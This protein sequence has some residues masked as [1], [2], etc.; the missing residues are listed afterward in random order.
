ML[1]ATV[2]IIY[3]A[4]KFISNILT[5]DLKLVIVVSRIYQSIEKSLLAQ[6]EYREQNN[7]VYLILRNRV[8]AHEKT[9]SK[10]LMN[11]IEE[12]WNEYNETQKAILLYLFRKGSA[13]L[14]DL[15]Q[16][17]GINQNSVRSYQSIE[18]SEKIA[19]ALKPEGALNVQLRLVNGKAIPFELNTRFSSTECV[20]AYYGYN[21][22]E[23][24]LDNYLF[25]KEIDL[26]NWK[27]GMFM[28][29]WHECYFTKDELPK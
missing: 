18:V 23:A 16:H 3:R 15:Q 28:R 14:S 8:S 5:T 11:A 10:A 21:S 13:V 20:R 25:G 12:K 24:M 22:I 17:T 1:F 19:E 29:Y 26:S 6:P 27:K 7:N 4:M 9:I 2:P